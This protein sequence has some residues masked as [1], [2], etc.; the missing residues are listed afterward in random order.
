MTHRVACLLCGF[1]QVA[2]VEEAATLRAELSV[3][4][5]VAQRQAADSLRVWLGVQGVL[6]VVELEA[7]CAEATH[8]LRARR[9]A[10]VQELR[11]LEQQV[12]CLLAPRM[13]YL[14]A[15]WLQLRLPACLPLA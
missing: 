10:R 4:L 11:T 1:V 13:R 6:P 5:S 15:R 9:E 2:D 8:E 14:L 3:T 7:L 12:S